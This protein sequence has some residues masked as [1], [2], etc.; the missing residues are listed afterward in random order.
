V[1]HRSD[2]LARAGRGASTLACALIVAIA[3]LALSGCGKKKTPAA[4]VP[5]TPHASTT[6]TTPPTLAQRLA[7]SHWTA[8]IVRRTALHTRAHGGHVI[9]YITPHTE[10]GSKTVLAVKKINGTSV[11]LLAPQ[12]GNGKVG[13]VRATKVRLRPVEYSMAV[14]R[15]RHQVIVRKNGKLLR[16]MDAA[17]GRPALPTPRGTFA[18]TDEIKF[19]PGSSYGYGALALTARQ[20]DLEPGWTGGDRVAI[21]GTDEPG[22]IGQE[23][24]HGCVRVADKNAK[25]LVLHVPAGT[26]VVVR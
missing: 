11:G 6:P 26:P 14:N 4:A 10:F 15:K 12:V 7:G 18:V 21:H 1:S 17:I 3:L 2:A 8:R 16:K 24:S 5:S 19:A 25:W 22:L 13:W 9:A 20:P 23:V